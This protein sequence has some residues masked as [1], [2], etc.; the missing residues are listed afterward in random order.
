MKTL[1][2]SLL[3]FLIGLGGGMVLPWPEAAEGPGKTAAVPHAPRPG[4]AAGSGG[5]AASRP[6]QG[7]A[8]PVAAAPEVKSDP[9][10]DWDTA[11]KAGTLTDARLRDRLLQR[12]AQAD[13]ARAWRALI[14]SSMPF[15]RQEVH[16]IAEAWYGKDP[17]AAAVFGLTLTDPLQRPAFLQRV[18]SKWMLEKPGAFAAWFHTQAGELDLAQYLGASNMVYSAGSCTLQELDSLLR[19]NPGFASFPDFLGRQFSAL[20]SQPEQRQAATNWLRRVADPALRDLLWK[21]A[22]AAAGEEEPQT[23]AA[24]LEEIGD[25]KTRRQ[26]SSTLAA[27][28]AR[29]D[30]RAALDYAATLPDEAA[31]R[32]AWQSAL[33][34]W[35]AGSPQQV[36]AYIQQNIASLTPDMI[37][38]AAR[39]LGQSRPAEAL[40]AVAGF[41]PS[42]ARMSLIMDLMFTWRSRRPEEARRWLE[43]EQAATLLV[44]DSPLWKVINAPQL[45]P[46]SGPATTQ[47]TVNGRP[48]VYTY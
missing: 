48:V 26:A 8:D 29:K 35:A 47:T 15:S 16:S 39:D 11:L 6:P 17:E 44:R 14:A 5:P 7:A 10:A 27:L 2:V 25:P 22:V 1:L 38:P 9:F 3:T 42:G 19:V 20:W 34:T 4:P 12:M 23:A 45:P 36:L 28:L 41:P 33:C 24:M 18:L 32:S 37:I 21:H 46:V 40:A 31:A 43:T 13:P 30:P